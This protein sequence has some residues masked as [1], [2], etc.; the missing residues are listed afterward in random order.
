MDTFGHILTLTTFGESH[1]PAIGGVLCGMPAGEPI[2]PA[3]VQAALDRRRP[4]GD[5]IGSRRRESDK[6]QLLSGIFEGKTLGTPIGFLITNSDARSSDY[7]QLRHTFRPNHADYTY[8]AKYGIRDFRGGGR[9][10]ARETACRVAAGAI[11]AQV[12]A[13]R[14]INICAYTSAIGDVSWR[15]DN[16]TPAYVYASP[17]RCPDK[18]AAELM[19]RQIEDAQAAGN[20]VGGMVSC[21]VTGVPAGLGEPLYG[22]L[23]AMLASAMLSI[24]AA[25]GFEYGLGFAAATAT[26]AETADIFVPGD[27]VTTRTNFSGGIQG[28]ISNGMD[29]CFSVAFKPAPT[30]MQPVQTVNDR[31]EATVLSMTGRHDPCV[32]PRAV[33]VVE[34]MV[35]LVLLDALLLRRSD[36]I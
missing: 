6:V 14:G 22:K 11:A 24:P 17:V 36:K 10:S 7:E 32:V 16:P 21:T 9:A 8:Q 3:S 18:S 33:P 25:K 30:L 13:R 1:G 26:G 29:I 12:L 19:R 2:D 27:P 15:C 35:A 20:T 34:A 4:G 31:G 5:A 28:G 23:Q